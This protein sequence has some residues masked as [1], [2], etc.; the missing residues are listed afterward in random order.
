MKFNIE[1]V[2][3]NIE[4]VKFNIE[5]AK[6]NIESM[7]L[8]VESLNESKKLHFEIEKTKCTCTNIW[9][10]INIRCL[11]VRTEKQMEESRLFQMRWKLLLTLTFKNINFAIPSIHFRTCPSHWH[12]DDPDLSQ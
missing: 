10:I 6:F 12:H 11:S 3:F 1:S 8:I 2:K 7:K 9:S 4:S 5:S